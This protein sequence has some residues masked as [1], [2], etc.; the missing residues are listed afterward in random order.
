MKRPVYLDHHATTPVDPRVLQQMLPYFTDHYGNASSHNHCFGWQAEEAVENARQ[1][2]AELIGATA[3]EIIFTSGATESNNL[4]IKG[5]VQA[6]LKQRPLR[7]AHVITVATEHKSVLDSCRQLQEQ[8]CRITVLPVDCN[9]MLDLDRLEQAIDEETALI[10][11]M[12]A[13]NEIGVLQPIAEIGRIAARHGVLFHSDAVQSAGKVPLDVSQCGVDLLS[14]SA[15]KMYGPKGVGVLYVR[16]RNKAVEI[17]AQMVGGGQER[18]V[19][20]GTLNV[21]GV[22]GMGAAAAVAQSVMRDEAGR[23]ALLRDRLQA[24]LQAALPEV[25]VNG[26]TQSRLPNNLSVSFPEVDGETLLA[27]LDDV[28]VS[29]GSA[30][31]S[32]TSHPSH[33]LCAIGLPARLALATVRFGIGRSTTE[34][35][36]DYAAAK[37]I[38]VVSTLKRNK[39]LSLRA[40]VAD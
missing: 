20:S 9:G 27:A 33:V 36:I 2:I 32:A 35:E 19:R 21:P 40:T 37:L 28:A 16:R 4:A 34:E 3:R 14:L 7:E 31:N 6:A 12:H 11:I 29:S 22:V 26:C 39:H 38:D 24:L 5:A 15:H 25:I 8:G 17:S 30:C 10:S 18:G 1:Q 23:M 13:N